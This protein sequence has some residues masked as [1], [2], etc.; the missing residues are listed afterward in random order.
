MPRLEESEIKKYWQIFQSLKPQNNKLTG[1]QL[2]SILKNSQLPQQQ[3]SAIWELS[4]I[5]NDGKLD[6]EEFCIIM[7]LIFDVINGNYPMSHKNYHHG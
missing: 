2:S 1:D 3:L 4:D 5:D 7:R 6:F